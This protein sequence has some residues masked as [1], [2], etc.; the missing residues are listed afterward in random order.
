MNIKTVKT[1]EFERVT[2][3]L[4]SEVDE[5]DVLLLSALVLAFLESSSV[6]LDE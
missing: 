4:D 6:N 1:N 3:D 5:S 2:T